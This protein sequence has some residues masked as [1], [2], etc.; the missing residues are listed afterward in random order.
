VLPLAPV[1]TWFKKTAPSTR[2]TLKVNATVGRL[3]MSRAP[4]SVPTHLPSKHSIQSRLVFFFWAGDSQT[5]A[6]YL[7]VGIPVPLAT[8]QL[9]TPTPTYSFASPGKSL[10]PS[11]EPSRAP[12]HLS[13]RFFI[14]FVRNENC[15][16]DKSNR[17]NYDNG[18]ST[19]SCPGTAPAEIPCD[20]QSANQRRTCSYPISS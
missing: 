15:Y 7:H 1:T 12:S 17:G 20:A 6:L 16:Y 8:P 10:L 18:L 9:L 2:R 5:L 13:L 4:A 11:T 19:Y 3:S 14:H